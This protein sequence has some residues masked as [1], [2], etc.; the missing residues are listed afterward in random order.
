VSA[1][2]VVLVSHSL[3]GG[4]GDFHPERQVAY[5]AGHEGH[6]SDEEGLNHDDN[7]RSRVEFTSEFVLR[8]RGEAELHQSNN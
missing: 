5:L 3:G 2:G 8:S 4:D 1:S 6:E 7:R